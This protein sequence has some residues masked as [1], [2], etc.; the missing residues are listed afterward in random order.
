MARFLIWAA[1]PLLI[2]ASPALAQETV[3]APATA[4]DAAAPAPAKPKKVCR[5]FQITGRRIAQTQCYTAAQWADIDRT[6]QDAA[7]RFVRDVNGAAAS[8]HFPGGSNGAVDTSTLFGLGS[9]Q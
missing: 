2:V 3:P 5:T 7:N 8:A 1:A 4:P 9:P 6:R